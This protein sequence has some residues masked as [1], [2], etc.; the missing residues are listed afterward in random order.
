MSNNI[1]IKHPSTLR[2]Q[3][4]VIDNMTYPWFA[5]KGLRYAPDQFQYSYTDLEETLIK[6]IKKIIKKTANY[7]GYNLNEY[8]LKELKATL[9]SINNA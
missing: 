4:Y 2:Q 5:Y 6:V 8:I 7:K 1:D 3:G 9:E